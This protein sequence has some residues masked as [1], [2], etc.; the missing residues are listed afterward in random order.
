[1]RIFSCI[2]RGERALVCCHKLRLDLHPT[3]IRNSPR[4]VVTRRKRALATPPPLPSPSC[5]T[6]WLH[7]VSLVRICVKGDLPCLYSLITKPSGSIGACV[8]A[9]ARGSTVLACTCATLPFAIFFTR[10]GQEL[11]YTDSNHANSPVCLL[12][13]VPTLNAIRYLCRGV[14]LASGA[15]SGGAGGVRFA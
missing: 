6:L 9:A 4:R 15:T 1:M 8:A 13:A 7:L 10:S 12:V 11:D 5:A 3:M 2:R 14:G